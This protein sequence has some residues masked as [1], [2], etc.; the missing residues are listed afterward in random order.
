MLTLNQNISELIGSIIGDGNIYNK[1]PAYVEITGNQ[2]TERGYFSELNKIIEKELDY[3]PKIFFRQGALRLRINNKE[4]VRFLVNDIGV[5]FGHGKFKKVVLPDKIKAK[6]SY[7]KSCIRGIFDTDG[8]V[9]FDL[10]KVYKAPYIKIE[11]HMENKK[12]VFEIASILRSFGINATDP[13]KKISLCINGQEEVIK[14]LKII[15]FRNS[16]HLKRISFY[17]PEL[18]NFNTASVTQW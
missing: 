18:L 9:Y 4:F 12:L 5:P 17:Y 16:G 3:T 8:S 14:Y 7:T 11:L 6:S 15:G 1:R 2:K 10:R 13:G